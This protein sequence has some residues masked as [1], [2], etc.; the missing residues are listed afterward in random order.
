MGVRWVDAAPAALRDASV[1]DLRDGSVAAL[2][3]DEDD[4]IIAADESAELM[5]G[6][7]ELLGRTRTSLGLRFTAADG[8]PLAAGDDPVLRTLASGEPSAPSLLGVESAR[9]DA[10]MSF[11][12]VEVGTAPLRLADGSVA[13]VAVSWREVSDQPRGRA[14]TAALVRALQSLSKAAVADE[15]RFRALAENAADVVIQS[16]VAGRCVWVSPA[17]RE[18]LGWEPD[19]VVGQSLLPL[20]H[21]DDRERANEQRRAALASG[22]D[23]H[24][25]LEVRYT[26]TAGGWRWMSA[27][28][29]PMRDPTG[30]VVGG[31]TALRDIQDDVE[32]R[33]ELRY[34][35]GHDGLTGLVNREAAI[36]H[37]AR[38]LQNTAG[39]GSLVGVLYLDVDRFKDVNDT[40]G[41]ATGDRLLIEIG[42]RLTTTLRASDIVARLGGD[43]FLVILS[44]VKEE[45][46]AV[47]R[48]MSLLEMV[49][50]P[51]DEGIPAATVS[52]GVVTDAGDRDPADVLHEADAA[53]YRA[54][55]AGRNTVSL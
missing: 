7:H 30:R 41:H 54:K 52:I 32:R 47:R 48:A 50:R 1:V 42:H 12:W 37:L 2:V 3:V 16:D 25:R 34:L 43:E 49:S 29:R 9:S 36:H 20:V 31:L 53:L 45:Q 38:A 33:E 10:G 40:Y 19:D 8:S 18:V 27:L 51:G 39:S 15:V 11:S 23:A 4:R 13:A 22:S 6:T 55:H 28:S 26:T 46:H 17:V 35:A 5:L 24:E 44:Q 21:P 14:A